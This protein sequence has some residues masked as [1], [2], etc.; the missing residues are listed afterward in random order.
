MH[1]TE[2]EIDAGL[3]GRLLAAQFPQWA[4]WPIDRRGLLPGRRGAAGRVS[5]GGAATSKWRKAG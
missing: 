5:S 1:A 4:D 3:V 2:L